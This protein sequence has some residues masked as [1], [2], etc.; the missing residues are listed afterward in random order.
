M[1]IV[2][3]IQETNIFSNNN[4]LKQNI[5][6]QL[7]NF[8]VKIIVQLFFPVIMIFF[9][10]TN[11]F[12]V[13]IILFTIITTVSG[14]NFNILEV[15]KNIMIQLYEEKDLKE[16][17]LIYSNSVIGHLVNLIFF[18]SIC[19]GV[20]YLFDFDTYASSSITIE[21]LEICFLFII[22]GFLIESITYLLYPIFTYRGY[23]KIWIN[24]QSFF[25]FHS[26]CLLVTSLLFN[27]F[28]YLGIF[29]FIS[30]LLRLLIILLYKN[31]ENTEKI[32]FNY[33]LVNQSILKKLF[34]KSLS[35]SLEKINYLMKQ[36]GLILIVGYLFSPIFVTMI[37]TARTLFYYLPINFF[38]VIT[39]P[40]TIEFG[41]IN[42][43]N[44]DKIYDL[45]RKFTYLSLFVA[46]L[47]FIVAN[48][49]GKIIYDIWINN[50]SINLLHS[51]IFLISL[52]A[53]LIGWINLLYAPF[54]SKNNFLFLSLI[55][56]YFTFIS[57]FLAIVVS[58]FLN[59]LDV[60][61]G[62]ITI[63]HFMFYIF[64]KINFKKFIKS[65]S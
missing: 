39:N 41:K 37:S 63:F 13:W 16:L 7:I 52:D 10:G 20:Y 36:N 24:Q 29:F 57:L 55:D 42:L 17:N 40:A 58:Y 53:I 49:V 60:L 25:Q 33:S 6:S 21:S 12:G 46:I 8:L 50:N 27:D 5:F 44:K 32:S 61:I 28:M 48:F 34:L 1:N 22:L 9:L 19:A 23:T 65:I 14:I 15:T 30:N 35:Y 45:L 2:K 43:K 51:T 38:D 18:I 64:I 31:K 3:L 26:K 47:Y 56:F 62:I 59:S 11:D 54:K 4:R